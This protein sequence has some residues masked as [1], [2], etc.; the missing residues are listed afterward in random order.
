M[1]NVYD[2][3][4]IKTEFSRKYIHYRFMKTAFVDLKWKKKN[5]MYA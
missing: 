5:H 2:P 4:G 1:L 3:K